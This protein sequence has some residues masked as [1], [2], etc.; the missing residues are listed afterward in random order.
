[1]GS[2]M[3]SGGVLAVITLIITLALNEILH[4]NEDCPISQSV[5]KTSH[6]INT[7]LLF[8]FA[9][10]VFYKVVTIV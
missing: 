4:V 2:Q 6:M 1:M 7:P 3:V 5:V 9:C 8:A 10:I